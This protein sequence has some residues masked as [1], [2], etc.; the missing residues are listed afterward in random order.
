MCRHDAKREIRV[1]Q[2][3][4]SLLQAILS[5]DMY[6][7][8]DLCSGISEHEQEGQENWN[9]GRASLGSCNLNMP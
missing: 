8:F 9:Y 3:Y 4:S 1:Q 2:V 5:A 6:Q 7:G